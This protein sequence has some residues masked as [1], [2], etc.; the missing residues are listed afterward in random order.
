MLILGYLIIINA[1]AFILMHKDKQKA[2]KGKWRIPE[3]TLFKLAL[4][5]GSFGVYLG[6]RM[7]RHKTKHLKFTIGI[8]VLM[9]IH[10]LIFIIFGI[11]L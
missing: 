5:G 6:M 7:F 3:A 1:I 11:I 8:P 2:I 10:I 4:A 9:A